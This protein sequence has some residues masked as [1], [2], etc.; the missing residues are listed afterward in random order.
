MWAGERAFVPA[1]TWPLHLTRPP[2]TVCREGPGSALLSTSPAAPLWVEGP[3]PLA[4]RPPP[5]SPHSPRRESALRFRVSVSFVTSSTFFGAGVEWA[6][7]GATWPGYGAGNAPRLPQGGVAGPRLPEQL[8][9]RFPESRWA[10]RLSAV[11]L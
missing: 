7:L 6:L 10:S 2:R 4:L 1:R 11:L 8:G 3:D 5:A 9:L